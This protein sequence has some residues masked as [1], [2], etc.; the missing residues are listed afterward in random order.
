MFLGFINTKISNKHKL[1]P[2]SILLPF[3]QPLPFEG[4]CTLLHFLENKQ[5]YNPHLL[6]NIEEINL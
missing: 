5:N 6:Y 2:L 1:L 4:K 3:Y